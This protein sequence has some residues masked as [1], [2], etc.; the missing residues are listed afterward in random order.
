MMCI[1]HRGVPG[2]NA[3]ARGTDSRVDVAR[4][5]A[6]NRGETGGLTTLLEEYA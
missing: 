3:E 5:A 4:D 1:L 2:A 6:R